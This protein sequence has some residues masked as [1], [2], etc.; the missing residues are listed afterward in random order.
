MRRGIGSLGALLLFA[1]GATHAER[2]EAPYPLHLWKDPGFKRAFL[3]EYG[4]D[5]AIEPP[6]NDIEKQQMQKL[7]EV[8][9]AQPVEALRAL[10]EVTTDKSSAEFH[11][12]LGQ[13]SL[14]TNQP[15]EK[16]IRHFE[17][18]IK[19]FPN[20]RRAHFALGRTL[21]QKGDFT[22]ALTSLAKAMELGRADPILYGLLGYCHLAIEN[23][24]SAESAYRMALVLQPASLDWKTGLLR[25]LLMQS[26]A[27][28]AIALCNEML[29]T[30]PKNKD[31]WMLQSNAYLLKKDF[32]RAA[33]NIELVA[34]VT[35]LSAS[36]YI[37][38][39]NIY[40][41]EQLHDAA[42]SAYQRAFST[43]PPPQLAEAVRV[44]EAL[45][46]R[47]GLDQ[48]KDLLASLRDKY[49]GQISDAERRQLMKIEAR[50][51]V[52]EGAGGKAAEVLEEVTKLDPLDGEA[53]M[54]LA[55]HYVSTG[56]KERAI[57]YY[58]R[59]EAIEAF[60]ADAAV[61]HAQLLVGMGK[62]EEA[63]PLLKRA[64][65]VKPRD[66]VAK[67]L[68]DLERYQKGRR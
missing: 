9:G 8:M 49:S 12:V 66:S 38:L 28:D 42:L 52:A 29:A 61:K 15:V 14:Q 57:L 3:R 7:S 58:Q 34:R 17:K 19:E 26:K 24:S 22:A 47:G 35:A 31:W 33:T 53:L 25:A 13:L 1:A 64:Q 23:A 63:I 4:A 32:L 67:Y 10:T 41:N 46:S 51:A 43:S 30:D 59:A 45:S 2:S 6:L 39:G 54:L 21:V 18:A 40:V 56:E 62:A 11:F 60:E 37:R 44:V 55:S 5:T 27:D 48:S 68:E 16:A 20:F 36:D 65:R 50:L